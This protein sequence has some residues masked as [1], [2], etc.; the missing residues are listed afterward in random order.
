MA[1]AQSKN[2]GSAGHPRT[3]HYERLTRAKL[4]ID[5]HFDRRIDTDRLAK[6]ASFSRFH[7]IRLFKAAY[8]RTPHQYLMYVRIERAKQILRSDTP[9]SHVCYLVGFESTSSFTGLFKRYV[10]STPSRYQSQELKKKQ[11]IARSPLQFIPGCFAEKH[12]WTKKSQFSR[13]LRPRK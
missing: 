10:G 5:R 4:Y 7:F 3:Y 13:S 11:E 1:T 2:N 8:G 9:V 12:G 6:E